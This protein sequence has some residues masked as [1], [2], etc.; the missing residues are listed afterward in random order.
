MNRDVSVRY[1]TICSSKQENCGKII[2]QLC[3]NHYKKNSNSL[4]TT[5][6]LVTPCEP[7]TQLF[8]AVRTT[9]ANLTSNGS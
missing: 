7:L 3:T 6:K 1:G 4:N 8:I 9:S 2:S 5:E